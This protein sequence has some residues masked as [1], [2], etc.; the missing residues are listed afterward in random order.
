MYIIRRNGEFIKILELWKC[1][2][3]K[4]L[5]MVVSTQKF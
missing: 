5:Q 4:G 2:F 3:Y 1:P